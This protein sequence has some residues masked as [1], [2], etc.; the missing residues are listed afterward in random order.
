MLTPTNKF[1]N[2]K[3]MSITLMIEKTRCLKVGIIAHGA[4]AEFLAFL[5]G[6]SVKI[7]LGHFCTIYYFI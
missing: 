2:G 4:Q 5:L 7:V 6:K 3:A 1:K